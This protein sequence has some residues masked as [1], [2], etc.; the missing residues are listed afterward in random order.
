MS[1]ALIILTVVTL[2]GIG[3]WTENISADET[4]GFDT[5]Y[6]EDPLEYPIIGHQPTYSISGM[7]SFEDA[8]VEWVDFTIGWND[9]TKNLSEDDTFEEGKTYTATF[10]CETDYYIP[11]DGAEAQIEFIGNSNYE[12]PIMVDITEVTGGFTFSVT[13][14][15]AIP[16]ELP[17]FD[18]ISSSQ[19][20]DYPIPGA[21]PVFE[22]DVTLYLEDNPVDDITLS[23]IWNDGTKNLTGEDVFQAGKT[24]TATFYVEDPEYAPTNDATAYIGF[25]GNDDYESANLDV[26]TYAEGFRFIIDDL[27]IP[28]PPPVSFSNLLT[29]GIVDYPLPGA[30]PVYSVQVALSNGNEVITF[31]NMS[32]NWNDGTKNLSG[33]DVFESGKTY[34]ATFSYI[35]TAFYPAQGA[36]AEVQIISNAGTPVLHPDIQTNVGGFSFSIGDLTTST[37]TPEIEFTSIIP[38]GQLQNYASRNARIDS[39]NFNGRVSYLYTTEACDFNHMATAPFTIGESYYLK[40]AV[41][42]NTAGAVLNSYALVN[43]QQVSIIPDPGTGGVTKCI[44]LPVTVQ[45]ET[46]DYIELSS[47]Y[48]VHN[49]QSGT[50]EYDWSEVSSSDITYSDISR[51]WWRGNTQLQD[52]DRFVATNTYTVKLVIP[53]RETST[54]VYNPNI[55]VKFGDNFQESHQVVVPAQNITVSNDGRTLTVSYDL[56]T[57]KLNITRVVVHF[58]NPQVGQGPVDNPITIWDHQPSNN[59]GVVSVSSSAWQINGTFQP[60]TEY[61]VNMVLAAGQYYQF[62][63]NTAV[64]CNGYT[65]QDR[66]TFNYLTGEAFATYTTPSP[67][68]FTGLVKD[69][70]G[71][72]IAGA[73]VEYFTVLDFADVHQGYVTTGQDGRFYIDA[74]NHQN[75][76]YSSAG[77]FYV[78]NVLKDGYVEAN[79]P[80][81]LDWNGGTCVIADVV[82]QISQTKVITVKD[83]SQ[84][85]I[86]GVTVY[87]SWGDGDENETVE[88][89]DASG[90][91]TLQ[92]G[93]QTGNLML[94]KE[95][96]ARFNAE[97][98]AGDIN[99]TLLSI[100]DQN[101]KVIRLMANNDTDDCL[102]FFY[103]T[104]STVIDLSPI[105]VE[106]LASHMF[107]E[108]D[109][110]TMNTNSCNTEPDGSGTSRNYLEAFTV[111]NSITYYVMWTINSANVTFFNGYDPEDQ[112]ISRVIE[113]GDNLPIFS[114]LDITY[115]GHEF[116]G[117][118]TRS[119]GQGRSFSN[120]ANIDELLVGPGV[121]LSLYAQWRASTYTVTLNTN[122]GTINAG[123]ITS[124]T[125]GTGATLPTDVT[126]DDYRFAGWYANANFDGDRI[127][128]IAADATGEKAYWA[129]WSTTSIESFAV[130]ND[131]FSITDTAITFTYPAGTNVSALVPTITVSDGCVVD[132]ASDVA[133]DFTQPVTYRVSLSDDAQ[134]YVDYRVIVKV[135]EATPDCTVTLVSRSSADDAA[136]LYNG[137]LAGDYSG[138][139]Y[140]VDGGNTWAD[141]GNNGAV[142]AITATNGLKLK[143]PASAENMA[144]SEVQNIIFRTISVTNQLQLTVNGMNMIA[145]GGNVDL[146][147]NTSSGYHLPDTIA[148]MKNGNAFDGYTYSKN[149]G[150]FT[151]T[152]IDGNLTVTVVPVANTYT[153][154]FNKNNGAAQGTME[155]QVFTYGVAQ[156]LTANAFTLEGYGMTGWSTAAEGQV[157]YTNGASVSNL[158][159]E[160]GATVELFAQWAQ[161]YLLT[162]DANGG[163]N[164]P[165]DGNQYSYTGTDNATV[166]DA[167]NMSFIG[168]KFT[169]WNTQA[170]G[171]GT[172]YATGSQILMNDNK[173]LYAV[174]SP[175]TYTVEFVGGEG[176]TGTMAAQ[177]MTYGTAADLS[178]N[179]FQKTGYTFVRWNGSNQA[180]YTDG[181]NVVN[182]TDQQ[183]GKIVLAAEWAPIT[184][185][186]EFYKND[187]TQEKIVRSATYDVAFTDFSNTYARDGYLFVKW[188][189]QANGN[190]TDYL[191]NAS[192]TNLASAQDAAVA[193]Y[194]VW[195]FIATPT[196]NTSS[197]SVDFGTDTSSASVSIDAAGIASARNSIENNAE[198]DK[199]VVRS[200]DWSVDIPSEALNHIAGNNQPITLSVAKMD[201]AE[202]PESVKA[203]TGDMQVISL[204]MMVDNAAYTDNFGG[205]LTI[206]VPYILKDGETADNLYI[207]TFNKATGQLSE[208]TKV[209]YADGNATFQVAHFSYWALGPYTEPASSGEFPIMIV[210]IAVVAVIAVAGAAAYFFLVKRKA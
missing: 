203:K 133:R 137:T 96:Y 24:Y 199:V 100:G 46:I 110:H 48:P 89:T 81:I 44:I 124:Y 47:D 104:G 19:D 146:S 75:F 143:A 164:A 25:T 3:F 210:A 147:F 27:E 186:F 107:C 78:F 168:Q 193:M 35:G 45:R 43:G 20:L 64:H 5:V 158:A 121:Q 131:Q 189:T 161:C 148:V 31:V 98:D 138:L 128:S 157:V 185:S 17:R 91:A 97:V 22:C 126:K 61:R 80:N 38:S 166:A 153:V 83:V 58:E 23:I 85:P 59:D 86:Q 21:Y 49:R 74:T 172:A 175:I 115:N 95:G 178:A 179:T 9:G 194:A 123:N 8:D 202:V 201:I 174:W 67:D 69:S 167:G 162:Y 33:D 151:V 200:S 141:V 160:N 101:V 70:S 52:S 152:G 6:F 144:D 92:V 11:E 15:T 136:F 142:L 204:N 76:P 209:T 129:K 145:D 113:F 34:T 109:G 149:T 182:L 71:Q 37:V 57:P 155:A 26:V 16:Q 198:I 112:G 163:N 132:P 192:A 187:E 40:L 177:S 117:W 88:I 29:Y 1:A 170:D 73:R 53:L 65:E 197:G 180:Q 84:N 191:T 72:P 176:A 7:T 41:L 39:E 190:G 28:E 32:I 77:A 119:D 14:L 79:P 42:I 150:A 207:W 93:A 134:T 111:E 122:G 12:D 60:D 18:S 50:T 130:G 103:E 114:T 159:T 154:T 2:A 36:I 30:T 68:A 173:T 125:Y 184:Y 120:F 4:V 156:N 10:F 140:S 108:W 13:N 51:T 188:N 106:L 99:H 127:T 102:E 82:M 208:R 171:N 55:V 169:G 206:T 63:E 183:G 90:V 56:D 66:I 135:R 139:K 165:S 116:T 118:N 94:V 62:A 54:K 181:Q 195:S 196:E 205:M 87:F 105:I